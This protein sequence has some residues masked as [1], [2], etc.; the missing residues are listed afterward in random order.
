MTARQKFWLKV[1]VAVT[2]PLWIAPAVAIGAAVLLYSLIWASVSYA[3][4]EFTGPRK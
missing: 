2:F 1:V 3:I 4:D